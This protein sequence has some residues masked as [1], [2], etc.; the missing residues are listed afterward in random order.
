[1]KNINY[2]VGVINKGIWTTFGWY[3][4]NTISYRTRSKCCVYHPQGEKWCRSLTYEVLISDGYRMIRVSYSVPAYRFN[5]DAAF[6]SY[7]TRS[8]K[9]AVAPSLWSTTNNSGEGWIKRPHSAE[10]RDG[11]DCQFAIHPWRRTVE[12]PNKLEERDGSKAVSVHLKSS[13]VS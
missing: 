5:E 3:S 12:E 11:L 4:Y 10:M 1:M 13:I 8:T 6:S 7:Q 9:N 2:N